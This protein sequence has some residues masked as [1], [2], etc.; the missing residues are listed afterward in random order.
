MRSYH[1]LRALI[2]DLES[3]RYR[4]IGEGEE[5]KVE[6]TCLALKDRKR[7]AQWIRKKIR[8]SG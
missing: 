6:E 5:F 1:L 8:E 7:G 4:Q 3:I 2:E